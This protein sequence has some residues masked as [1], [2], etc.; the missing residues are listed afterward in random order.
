MSIVGAVYNFYMYF[1]NFKQVDYPV[2]MLNF[3]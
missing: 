3:P 1:L 2:H